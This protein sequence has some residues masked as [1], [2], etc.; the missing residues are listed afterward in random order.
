M[1]R[2]RPETASTFP[3]SIRREAILQGV[4]PYMSVMTSTPV[5][6]SMLFSSLLASLNMASGSS[7]TL[8]ERWPVCSSAR[9]STWLAEASRSAP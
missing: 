7:L 8:T 4:A 6:S 3:S 2:D 5:P 1:G 9:P